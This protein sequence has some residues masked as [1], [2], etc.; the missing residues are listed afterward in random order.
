MFKVPVRYSSGHVEW[1]VGWKSLKRG[2]EL[3]S[4]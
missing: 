2:K 3:Y 4:R 1:E